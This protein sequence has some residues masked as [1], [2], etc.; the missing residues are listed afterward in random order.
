MGHRFKEGEE[1]PSTEG[2]KQHAG[3]D[4]IVRRVENGANLHAERHLGAEHL[5][6]YLDGGLDGALGPAELLC[7]E[8]VDVVGEFCRNDD[9]EDKLHAPAS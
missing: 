8:S 5:R 6:E 2:C 3:M 9:I 7:L 4:G 1:R